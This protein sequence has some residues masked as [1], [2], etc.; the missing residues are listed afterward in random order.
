MFLQK[1]FLEKTDRGTIS[2]F[3]CRSWGV[4]L[5]CEL[6]VEKQGGSIAIQNHP[7]GGCEVAFCVLLEVDH[8]SLDG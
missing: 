2:A 6:L 8:R 1:M 7:A 5:A 4:W 3:L